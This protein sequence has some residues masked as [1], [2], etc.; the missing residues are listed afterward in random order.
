MTCPPLCA[1]RHKRGGLSSPM[2]AQHLQR[3]QQS[4]KGKLIFVGLVI[5]E[6]T[7]G[8]PLMRG[9]VAKFFLL[10]CGLRLLVKRSRKVWSLFFFSSLLSGDDACLIPEPNAGRQKVDHQTGTL[11]PDVHVKAPIFCCL[12]STRRRLLSPLVFVANQLMPSSSTFHN[13]NKLDRNGHITLDKSDM[14]TSVGWS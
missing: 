14:A 7:A 13:S 12:L 10:P 4:G 11:D 3:V 2:Y 1:R 8:G 9:R 5:G 6:T